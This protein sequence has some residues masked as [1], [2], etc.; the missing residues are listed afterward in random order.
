MVRRL[1]KH[2]GMTRTVVLLSW[3]LSS[4]CSDA[5][6]VSP[7]PQPVPGKLELHPEHITAAVDGDTVVITGAAGASDVRP[8]TLFAID[9]DSSGP[10]LSTPID[11][12]GGF[13]LPLSGVLGH[14]VRLQAA[15]SIEA[16]RPLELRVDPSSLALEIVPANPCTIAPLEALPDSGLVAKNQ[17]AQLSL[18]LRAPCDSAVT[19]DSIT[20]R[21]GAS[22]FTVESAPPSVTELET[23]AGIGFISANAGDYRDLLQIRTT[24][25]TAEAAVTLRVV[26]SGN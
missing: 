16:C 12:S 24:P 22:G 6:V 2:S 9:L 18:P 10:E 14:R 8:A 4:A 13:S 20:L 1:L 17:A 21:N 15:K 19:I 25:S 7:Q 26:V 5:S 11:E 3:L 23:S